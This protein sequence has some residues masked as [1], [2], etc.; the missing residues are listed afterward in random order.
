[1]KQDIIKGVNAMYK[2]TAIITPYDRYT[3]TFSTMAHAQLWADYHESKSNAY[4]EIFHIT[5]D[6]THLPNAIRKGELVYMSHRADFI[7]W[8][9]EGV[10]NYA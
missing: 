1:M 10:S 2:A 6:D 7:A 9:S 4:C 8:V 3:D 5:G